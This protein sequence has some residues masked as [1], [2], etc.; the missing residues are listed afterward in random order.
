[1]R[2]AGAD[3]YPQIG[4]TLTGAKQRQNF[5]G[6]PFGAG[7]QSTLINNT[8]TTYE[9]RANMS[10][11]IDLWGRI[12]AARE[13]AFSDF[14]ASHAELESAHLS[15]AA[16]TARAWFAV[17]EARRQVRLATDTAE[18]F[19]RT[20]KQVKDR[21]ET[22][23]SPQ[24]DLRLAT[25]N[26]A[27]ADALLDAA[28]ILLEDR[29]RRLEIL[30]GRYPAGAIVTREQ[31]PQI[32]APIPTGLPSELLVRR[33]DIQ[34]AEQ[35]LVAASLRIDEARAALYPSI[36]LTAS[37]GTSSEQFSN[38]MSRDFA[39]WS[40]SGDLTQPLFEGGRRLAAIDIA[41]GQAKEA[42]ANYANKVLK[43]FSEVEQAL[44]KENLL[45]QREE[46]LQEATVEAKKARQLSE[47]RYNQGIEDLITLLEAQRRALTNESQ[48]IAVQRERLDARVD[49]HLALGGDFDSDIEPHE[50]K[51]T[52][53]LILGEE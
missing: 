34:S 25:T 43:A 51:L 9:L 42:L 29:L 23:V 38:L 30:L 11:E 6:F 7:G 22:G 14:Q 13:A 39:V 46:S 24:V 49:L 5:I 20:E 36:S 19:R 45:A 16:A 53:D 50:T 26:R 17:I 44:I 31:L 27:S 3:L 4:G 52:L 41:K 1:M 35:Q 10:W 18:T 15:L 33:L 48:L 8:F 2:L 32:P 40:V 47:D 28:V 12:R 21:V 37:G